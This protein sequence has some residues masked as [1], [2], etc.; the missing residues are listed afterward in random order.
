MD[1]KKAT[2]FEHLK[3]LRRVLIVSLLA[4]TAG[5]IISYTWLLDIIQKIV[6]NPILRLNQELVMISVTEGFVTKLKFSLIGGL[7]IA[8]PLIFWQVLSF[9]LPALY[10]K[11]QK[12][13]WPFLMSGLILFMAGI[14]FGYFIVLELGLA[15]LLGF[16]QGL[17][18]M[19]SVSKYVSF[20]ISFL[21][22]FGLIFQIPLVTLLLSKLGIVTPKLLRA[23]RGYVVL[24][25]FIL[26]AVFSPGSDVMTQ[27]L[28]ALPMIILFEISIIIAAIFRPSQGVR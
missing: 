16:S 28:M 24:G 25:I 22:P 11:E 27:I 21:F 12:V 13:L 8:S 9:V 15:F 20:F 19:I 2:L 17:T 4:A 6:L 23:K 7:I 10:K 26:A 1:D 5:M 3:E 14:S 18:P